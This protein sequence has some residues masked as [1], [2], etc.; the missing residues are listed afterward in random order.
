MRVASFSALGFMLVLIVAIA[1]IWVERRPI[2]R[3][4]LEREFEERGVQATYRLDRIGLRTQQVSNLVIGDPRRPDLVARRAIIQMRV[5]WDGGFEV[6]RIVARGVRLRGRLVGG[7]VSWGQIDKLLPPPTDKPFEL[8]AFVLDIADSSISLATPFGPLGFAVNGTGNLSG[9]FKG[10][11][12]IASP[13]LVP[14]RCAATNLRA[15]V[16]VGVVARRPRVD[17]PVTLDR[18]AC[19]A[20]NFNIAAPRFDAKAS[21]NEAFTRV[22]GSGRMAIPLLVASQRRWSTARRPGWV[23]PASSSAPTTRSGV[24]RV[25]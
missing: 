4:Y 2:A 5:K 3:Y 14:G 16:A 12:A 18:F 25:E 21:F 13:R 10:R 20:S 24:C 7:R 15:N 1:V 17:G 6:Y 9:G 22:D 19:P 8:P 11:L 23:A